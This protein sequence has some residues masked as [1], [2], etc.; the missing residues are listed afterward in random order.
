M[1][2]IRRNQHT[3][4]IVVIIAAIGVGVYF[5]YD[6]M[7]NES[8]NIVEKTSKITVNQQPATETSIDTDSDALPDWQEIIYGTDARNPDTDG[9]GTMDGDEVRVDRDPTKPGPGDTL[10]NIADNTGTGSPKSLFDMRKE[11]FAEA[12]AKDGQKIREQSLQEMVQRTDTQKYRPRYSVVELQIISDSSTTA[13]KTYVNSVATVAK[14]YASTDLGYRNEEEILNE[15]LA[16][17]RQSTIEELQ[18]PAV[19]YRNFS[20]E[21]RKITV[22]SPMAQIH[23]SLVNG[24]DVMSRALIDMQLLMRDPLQGNAA[25]QAYALGRVDV[26]KGFTG[27]MATIESKPLTFRKNEPGY[28]FLVGSPNP[29]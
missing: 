27:I 28:T 18:Y 21:L 13:L 6:T 15:A 10:Y 17:K 24:Y 14:K 1:E 5:V 7:Q 8:G 16:S 9:D 23:L 4:L 12:L 19:G 22:P 2:Q 25:Y 3:A 26:G 11:F 20:E 29:N